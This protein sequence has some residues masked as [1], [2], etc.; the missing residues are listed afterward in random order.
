MVEM[1]KPELDAQY[2]VLGSVLIEPDITGEVLQAVREDD[3]GDATCKTI[4]SAIK[5]LYIAGSRID[6]V[7]VLNAIGGQYREYLSQL[8]DI[9]PTAAG[10]RSYAVIMREQAKLYRIRSLATELEDCASVDAAQ[11]IINRLNREQADKSRRVVSLTDG[12]KLFLHTQETNPDYLEFGIDE[13]D[14]GKLFASK[15]DFIVIG[16]RPSVGKTALAIQMARHIGQTQKVGFFSLETNAEKFFDRYVSNA[17]GTGFGRIKRRE[18]DENDW[19][20]IS[21]TIHDDVK[22]IQLEM[23]DAS[24]MSVDDIRAMTLARRFD[25]IFVDYL[26]LISGRERDSYSRVTNISMGLHNLAQQANVAVISLAQLRRAE[27]ST[28][29][30]TGK[31]VEYAPTLSDLRESGQIEQDADIVMLMYL[32]DPDRRASDRILRIA[33]N[34]EGRGGKVTL[35]FD[36]S[37]QRFDVREEE[38]PPKIGQAEQKRPK[39]ADVEQIAMPEIP[40]GKKIY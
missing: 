19:P 18:L 24:G 20:C 2:A 5:D 26:Q 13:L 10:W 16:A 7:I 38:A 29:R 8:M 33:K 4:F 1:K 15:G 25:V 22:G 40:A 34:K 37:R 3:F 17:T 6:A 9:T 39:I 35:M 30:K 31:T 27:R 11:E 21:K 28:D 12:F 36:G 23:I 14:D 32:S